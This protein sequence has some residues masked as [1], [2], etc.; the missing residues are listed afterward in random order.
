M[1][2]FAWG[3]LLIAAP[4]ELAL[5]PDVVLQPDAAQDLDCRDLTQKG[6][7]LCRVEIGQ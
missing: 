6:G 3:K 7:S 1:R 2:L 5:D 4:A